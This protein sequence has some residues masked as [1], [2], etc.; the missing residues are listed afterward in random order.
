MFGADAVRAIQAPARALAARLLRRPSKPL[1]VVAARSWEIAPAETSVTPPALFLPNQL[2]R[3]T[4]W[5]FATEHPARVVHGRITAQHGATR[6]FLLE[7]A[8]LLDGVLYKGDASEVLTPRFRRRLH[9]QV[10]REVEQ[11]AVYCS[12]V[13]NK[14][15][16]NW[17]MDDCVTYA[18]AAAEG[19]PITTPIGPNPHQAAYEAWLDMRPVRPQTAFLRRAV[20]F[21]DIP[22][23]RSKHRRFR[24]LSRKL[25]AHVEARPHPGVFILRGGSGQRRMLANEAEI[26]QHLRER[27]GFR[28]LDPREADL[29]SIMG[30]CAGAQVVAGVEGSQLL[31]GIMVL[32]PGGALLTLQPPN[33]FVTVL[34]DLTDRDQQHF[35]FVVGTPRGEDF[36]VSIEEVERTLEMIRK[37][38]GAGA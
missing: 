16:G 28:V 18:L 36:H 15:F 31:H 4:G 3:V 37:V 20:V 1:A 12:Y 13:G 21:Q 35:A 10:E 24:E 27:H 38:Q 9:L 14:Y 29:P 22:Q 6:A 30:A 2:E 19:E 32:Q 7:N 26:A 11:G 25:L 23:N 33:R 34:K 17:L 5:E 8:W